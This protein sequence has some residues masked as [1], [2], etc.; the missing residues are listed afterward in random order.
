MKKCVGTYMFTKDASFGTYLPL[1]WKTPHALSSHETPTHLT[2]F[3]PQDKQIGVSWI[4]DL[5]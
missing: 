3:R 4:V 2:P 1:V 5:L